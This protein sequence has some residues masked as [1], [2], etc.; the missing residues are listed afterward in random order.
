MKKTTIL[1][2]LAI[3]VVT[4]NI[5][6]TIVVFHEISSIQIPFATIDFE[7]TNLNQDELIAN[8]TLHIHNPNS[9][10]MSLKNLLVDV[11][12]ENDVKIGS[13][14]IGDIEIPPKSLSSLSSKGS[15][16]LIMLNSRE[17]KAKVRGVLCGNILGIKKKTN[18]GIDILFKPPSLERIFT[19]SPFDVKTK[20]DYTLTCRGI[21]GHVTIEIRN[22]YNLS[23]F[24]ENITISLY[25]VKNGENKLLCRELVGG[26]LVKA[27]TTTLFEKNLTIPYKNLLKHGFLSFPDWLRTALEATISMPP[28]NQKIRIVLEGYQDMHLLKKNL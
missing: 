8:L 23:L 17:I 10:S 9:F 24:F 18:L 14:E 15:L 19:D 12:N 2:L 3:I 7:I 27:R 1:T 20:L 28:I 13:I 4:I 22:P 16:P 5:F 6:V 11:L 26:G 21:S 25:T